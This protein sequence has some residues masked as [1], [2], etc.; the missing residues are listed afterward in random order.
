RTS[1]VIAHRLSTIR[2]ADRI[3]V[4]EDGRIAE[5]GSHTEL[6]QLGGHYYRL[7]TQQ[8]RKELEVEYDPFAQVVEQALDEPAE[9]DPQSRPADTGNGHVA[10]S[11]LEFGD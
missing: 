8:F 11:E 6:L 10:V 3:L 7:Y 5:M 2:N 4:I 1:F 9:F